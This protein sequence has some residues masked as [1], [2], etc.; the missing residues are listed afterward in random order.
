MFM[1]SNGNGIASVLIKTIFLLLGVY[2]IAINVTLWA[3]SHNVGGEQLHGILDDW[4]FYGFHSSRMR[5]FGYVGFEKFYNL[6]GTFPGLRY[7]QGITS[8]Y[9]DI[10]SGYNVTGI[11]V[12]DAL[13]G[14]VRI[15]TA[16]FLLTIT[17]VTDI[18]NNVV[19][20]LG[21]LNIVPNTPQG[22]FLGA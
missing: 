13:F 21:F 2:V 22:T 15:L 19:W 12:I 1:G 3:T 9:L 17:I 6:L 16:P 10:I 4:N 8:T 7:T 14:L 11:G 18:I 20:F 5:D